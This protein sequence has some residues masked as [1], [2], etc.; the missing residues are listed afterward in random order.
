M[1]KLKL[2]VWLL[3][4][5]WLNTKDMMTRRHWHF[6]GGPNCIL[7]RL[8][9]PETI[10]SSHVHLLWRAGISSRLSGTWQ[11]GFLGDF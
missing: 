2:F 4:M 3:F 10:Y 6:E 5:D 1:S 7:C 11:M 9:R 8:D